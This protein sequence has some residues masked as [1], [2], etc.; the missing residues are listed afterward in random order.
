MKKYYVNK[1]P[2]E[3]VFDMRCIDR[4]TGCI[5]IMRPDQ[6]VAT[7]LPLEDIY[8]LAVYFDDLC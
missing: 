1:R 3:N 5:V 4:Q 7:I 2:D 8:G 6:Y